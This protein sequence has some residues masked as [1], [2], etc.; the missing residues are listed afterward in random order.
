MYQNK[1]LGEL[2][3]HIFAIADA[4]F[5][6]MLRKKKNQCIVISGESGSKC[7]HLNRED[8]TDLNIA[9]LSSLAEEN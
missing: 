6:T 1:R 4:A 2:P 3:P 5:Y 7:V 8:C 9:Y